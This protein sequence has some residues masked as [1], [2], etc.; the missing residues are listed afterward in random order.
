MEFIFLFVTLW[1]EPKAF[2]YFYALVVNPVSYLFS[3]Y[4]ADFNQ[5]RKLHI[6]VVI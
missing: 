4:P 3:D 2:I 5:K 6:Y 1:T